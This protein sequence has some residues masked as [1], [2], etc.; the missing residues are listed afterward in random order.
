M[1]SVGRRHSLHTF[2]ETMPSFLLQISKR[3][4][5]DECCPW[6]VCERES[7]AVKRV[8]FFL[9]ACSPVDPLCLLA[10]PC[11]GPL[12]TCLLPLHR[13][14]P[15]ALCSV[16]RELHSHLCRTMNANRLNRMQLREQQELNRQRAL[17]EET[18][19]RRFVAAR[20]QGKQQYQHVSSSGY[21]RD[22]HPPSNGRRASVGDDVQIHV[23]IRECDGDASQTFSYWEN[24]AEELGGRSVPIQRAAVGTP[25]VGGPLRGGGVAVPGA[26]SPAGSTLGTPRR[27]KV[28]RYLQQ[29]KAELQA[30]KDLLE[31]ERQRQVELA[32]IPSGQRLV[33][34]DEKATT[35]ARLEERQRELETQLGKI[36][37]RF[38]T[39]SIKNRRRN[40][41]QELAEIEETKLKY[42]TK[43]PLYVPLS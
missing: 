3:L 40:I 30:E 43:K 36:P 24:S 15:E 4:P 10:P 32:K 31:E 26:P 11:E 14:L 42:G 20:A 23:F 27:G 41:E 38:D 34:E 5:A 28:P 29:R 21:G 2:E 37:I 7:H 6:A 35:M 18:D 13:L 25:Q 12:P 9:V 39:Q 19:E 8:A 1:G 33:S 22:H 16:H 17:V